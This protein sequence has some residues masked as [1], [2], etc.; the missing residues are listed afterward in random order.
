MDFLGAFAGWITFERIGWIGNGCF[1]ARWV[2]QWLDAERSGSGRAPKLFWILS[3]LGTMLVGTY[4]ARRGEAILVAGFVTNGAI[5]LRNL[6]ILLRSSASRALPMRPASA[7]AVLA[8]VLLVAAAITEEARVVSAGWLWMTCAI[9]GQGLWSGRFVLQWWCSERAGESHFPIA[10][11]GL[12]L[13]GNLLLLAY[14]IHLSDPVL[15]VGLAPGPLMQIRNLMLAR[16]A[17]DQA[18]P[19]PTDPLPSSLALR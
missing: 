12:S 15:I 17:R 5:Y 9:V 7:I 19:E 18:A 3:L 1:F 13:A 14:A 11:W 6:Q 2:V 8:G 4:A 16:T 10:F